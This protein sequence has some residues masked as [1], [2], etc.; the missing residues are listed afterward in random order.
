LPRV[1]KTSS[2]EES[3][4]CEAMAWNMYIPL[5]ALFVTGLDISVRTILKLTLWME[6]S[7]KHD[8][9]VWCFSHLHDEGKV[10]REY[11][12]PLGE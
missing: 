1:A 8:A 6:V 11:I 5:H 3:V 12:D 4:H 9:F 2:T 7:R 10:S